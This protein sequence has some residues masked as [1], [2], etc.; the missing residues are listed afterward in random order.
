MHSLIFGDYM[1]PGADPK[2]YEEV[3]D[4]AALVPTIEEYLS[5]YNAESKTPMK[6]VMFLDAIEHVSKISRVLRQPQGN[7]LLFG[8]GGSGRQSLTRVRVACLPCVVRLPFCDVPRLVES[9][10][11]NFPFIPVSLLCYLVV[12]SSSWRRSFRTTS[13]SRLRSPRATAPTSGRKT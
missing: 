8:V 2:L 12:L 4:L 3:K 11:L 10:V 7:A 13:C 1:V 9:G 6:L 5:D